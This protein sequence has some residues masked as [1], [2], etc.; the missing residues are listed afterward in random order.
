M[1]FLLLISLH[2]VYFIDPKPN[3]QKTEGKMHFSYTII[4]VQGTVPVW[5]LEPSVYK[6]KPVLAL[7][8]R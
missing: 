1:A 3:L 5:L 7:V 4:T 2:L 6:F 8:A